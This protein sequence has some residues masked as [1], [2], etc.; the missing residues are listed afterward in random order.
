MPLVR[1]SRLGKLFASGNLWWRQAVH[2][3]QDVSFDIEPGETLGLVGESG[4]G[5]ST[6]GRMVVGLMPPTAG[7]CE[8]RRACGSHHARSGA[9]GACGATA[10]MVFQDPYSSLNPRMTVRD[11]LA[12]PLRNFGIAR[13]AAADGRIAPALDAC[14]LG[15]RAAAP[16]SRANS[17]AASASASA[18]PAR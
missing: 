5:K 18:S 4:S 9:Q 7:A 10:Q 3:V 14:G 16:L 2:A 15:A 12:E 17:P 13:G 1:A 8:R 11:A 6:L